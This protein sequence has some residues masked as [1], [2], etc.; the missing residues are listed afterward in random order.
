MDPE[1]LSL[2]CMVVGLALMAM[3]AAV[4]WSRFRRRALLTAAGGLHAN[5][6][7]FFGLGL[8]AYAGIE[9]VPERISPFFIMAGIWKAGPYL[10]VGYGAVALAEIRRARRRSAQLLDDRSVIASGTPRCLLAVS[11]LAIAGYVGS[12]TAFASSGVGTIFPVLKVF[13]YPGLVMSIVMP[14]QRKLG[15]LVLAAAY[16]VIVGWLAMRSPWRS[17]IVLAVAAVSLALL[18][19]LPRYPI[20]I[21]LFALIG[22]SISLPFAHEKKVRYEE[23]MVDPI[24]ALGHTL[25][26]PPADRLMFVANFWAIRINGARE[27][28]H[29]VDGLEAG[30]VD[31]RGGLTYW[32]ALQQLV[33]RVIWPAKPSFNETT[34]YDLA[35]QLR[36]L[37]WEDFDTSW[38]ISI[39]AEAVWNF[40]A[41]SLAIFIPLAFWLAEK[42][43]Y[44]VARRTRRLIAGWL[45]RTSLFFQFLAIV[46]LV[47]VTTY[48]LW[49]FLVGKGLDAWLGLK[50]HGHAPAVRGQV[51]LRL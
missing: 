49:S 40:G 16:V 15:N 47:N 43:D 11:L 24:S 8:V 38:G 44:V 39:Y 36:L 42:V 33:P 37:G 23:V 9:T 22:L 35:R 19:R 50:E 10:L 34:N 13:L 18:V 46:G 17:E 20:R 7:I 21:G 29:V 25:R 45:I 12:T 5:M 26:M 51:A 31:L 3:S 27:I 32:E 48:V 14:T 28:G 2:A 41:L 30:R 1:S 4:L 6:L